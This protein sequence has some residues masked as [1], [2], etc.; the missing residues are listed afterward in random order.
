MVVSSEQISVGDLIK[1]V[2]NYEGVVHKNR[3][4]TPKM[5]ALWDY[6]WGSKVTT[7]Q[8]QFTGAAYGLLPIARLVLDG[9]STLRTQVEGETRIPRLSKHKG[10]SRVRDPRSRGS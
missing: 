1:F 6:N 8:G 7:Q 4:N 9:L 3:P 2:A 5:E 10:L